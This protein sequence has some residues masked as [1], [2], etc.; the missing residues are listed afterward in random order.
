[1]A[2]SC[3]ATSP[4]STISARAAPRHGD[5]QLVYK[6]AISTVMPMGPIPLQDNKW[7]P[8][9]APDQRACSKTWARGTK[10]IAPD[11]S[12]VSVRTQIPWQR[13]SL[14]R[15]SV[16]RSGESHRSYRLACGRGMVARLGKATPA[17]LIG[18]GK[19]AE[20][21]ALTPCALNSSSSMRALVPCSNAISKR[22]GTPGARP[23][24][25][26]SRNLRRPARTREGR[27]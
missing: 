24:R 27:L 26:H 9:R 16:W 10:N 11:A 5:A 4:G 13:R 19:V 6:H 1:M 7:A 14:N 21:K 23:H 18:T 22:H 25:A 2:S 15:P 12:L 3:R 17:T 20:I 8:P